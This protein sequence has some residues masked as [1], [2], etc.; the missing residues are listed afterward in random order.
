MYVK[1]V[2]ARNLLWEWTV[3]AMPTPLPKTWINM[4]GW[5]ALF[6]KMPY[7]SS[8]SITVRMSARQTMVT[9]S[10]LN[11]LMRNSPL[12]TGLILR[13]LLKVLLRFVV[14]MS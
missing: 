9:D 8:L 2:K 12:Y 14:V 11:V 1:A 5:V 6:N 7:S 4:D 3:E 10:S 13:V